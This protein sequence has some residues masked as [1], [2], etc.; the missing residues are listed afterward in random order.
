MECGEIPQAVI[1]VMNIVV[2]IPQSIK[3]FIYFEYCVFYLYLWL[4]YSLSDQLNEL[5]S[6]SAKLLLTK[7][8]S[9]Y[10]MMTQ[11]AYY[12][13]QTVTPFELEGVVLGYRQS[14]A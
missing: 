7:R 14:L 12:R 9:Y 2:T 3:F 11:L 5:M 6:A 1:V 4:T 10:N 8:V 13:L